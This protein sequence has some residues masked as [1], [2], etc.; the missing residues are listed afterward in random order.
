MAFD[1]LFRHC[2]QYHYSFNEEQTMSFDLHGVH[3]VGITVRDLEVSRAW[4]SRMFD[5][6]PGPVNHGEGP[7][8][9]QGVQVPDAELAFSMIAIGSTRIEFLQYRQPEGEDFDLRNCDVGAAHVCFE[10]SDIDA[11][12]TDLTA[13]GVMF[14]GDP[15]E[16][17][18]G[19]L[20][21]SRWVYFRDPDGIQL[22][23]WQSPR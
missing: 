15:V 17:T 23:L 5:L 13:K 21:G 16:I 8:L 22:E 10:V 7:E 20:A 2:V 9:S 18:E 3:H 14:S 6:A 1:G 19:A 11:A 12:V 4:Y